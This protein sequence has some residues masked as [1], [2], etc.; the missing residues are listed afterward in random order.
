MSF[1]GKRSDPLKGTRWKHEKSGKYYW[2]VR[3]ARI[4][5]DLSE[6]VV[7]EDSVGNVWVRPKP[8]FMDGRFTQ[9]STRPNVENPCSEIYLESRDDPN[10]PNSDQH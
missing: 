9:V 8:E 10:I 3:T 7:Y 4:E 2:I 5:A 1:G 6:A